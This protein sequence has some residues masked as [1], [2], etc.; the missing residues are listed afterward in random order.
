MIPKE[1]LEKIESAI[2]KVMLDFQNDEDSIFSNPTEQKKFQYKTTNELKNWEKKQTCIVEG[3]LNKSILK[4]HT[5]QKSGSL[6]EISED[7]HLLTPRFNKDFGGL[8]IIEIGINNASTFPGY[9][10]KHEDMFKDFEVNKDFKN[11]QDLSLQLYRTVCREIVISKNQIKNL[12]HLIKR[13]KEFRNDKIRDAIFADIGEEVINTSDLD[14]KDV[15]FTNE[16]ARL[17]KANNSLKERYR[18]LNEFLIVY[19]NALNNDLTKKKF[20]KTAYKA[21]TFDR[22]IPVALAG[23]GNFKIKLKTKIK[24][25]EVIFNVIPLKDKTYI[26]ISTLK[27]HITYLNAYMSQ[28]INPLEF[29][30][31]VE[32]WMIHGSDH[33]FLSPSVWNKIDKKKQTEIIDRIM[34]I[35]YNIGIEFN[36]TIFNDLK[37]ESIKLMDDHYE[38]LKEHHIKLLEKE[39]RKI[40]FANNV[41]I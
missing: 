16:D 4:S 5:I 40:T 7:G 6:K 37:S 25:V 2:D 21:I 3:C 20:Q 19:R 18:Y 1:L 34:D 23:R 27:K 35:N 39:K 9:C 38:E 29:V 13:Y 28:F 15:K 26:F 17:Y 10:T 12:E 24:E 30:S 33:W 14:F 22:V 32:C 8:E 41:Y 31:M 11:G 36:M